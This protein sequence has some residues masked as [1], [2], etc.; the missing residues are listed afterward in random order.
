MDAN[1]DES[2]PNNWGTKVEIK[3]VNS[4][5]GVREAIN[6]EIKRQIS[7]KETNEYDSMEQQTR[8]W[9]EESGTTIYMRSKVDAIDYKYFVE[10]NIPR[11]KISND[12]LEE[13]KESIPV[14]GYQRNYECYIRIYK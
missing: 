9:D 2:N 13:I 12:W 1:L 5:G 11:F 14:L 7:L 8:R 6:Y 10:P 3:N 4:F